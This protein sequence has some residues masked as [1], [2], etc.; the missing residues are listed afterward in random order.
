[1]SEQTPSTVIV[2]DV[3]RHVHFIPAGEDVGFMVRHGIQPL[4]AV[5]LYVH[6][7]RA[8]N[9]QIVDHHGHTH[10]RTGVVLVQP[11]DVYDEGVSHCKW[12][13]YQIS[14]ALSRPEGDKAT[15]SA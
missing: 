14:Q 5:V 1:M 7:E 3:G 11:N 6:N 15:E 2:P 12:M 4:H 9:L 10:T 13:S 8:V